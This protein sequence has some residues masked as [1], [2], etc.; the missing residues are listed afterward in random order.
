MAVFR[1]RLATLLE[2]KAER[3]KECEKVLAERRAERRR[4]GEELARLEQAQRALEQEVRAKRAAP[5][6]AGSGDDWQARADDI[7]VYRQKVDDAK[8]AV[9]SQELHISELE[10]RVAEAAAA[11][12]D[13]SREEE[14]LEKH[15]AK[16]EA[17]WRA[18]Q[19]RKEALEQ[20]EIAAAMFEQRR[21]T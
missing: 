8:G 9:F 19:E 17:E 16:S 20:E 10:Q 13:A 14:T 2:Q 1:Y 21:R 12:Q 4:A 7:E 5:A 3:K 6:A 11:L 15:R 18:E